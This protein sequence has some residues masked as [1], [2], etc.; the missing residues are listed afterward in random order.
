MKK[1]IQPA[2][3]INDAV[4]TNMIA[5]SLNDSTPS[6]DDEN[7]NFAKEDDIWN[8]DIDWED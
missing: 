8:V 6:V 4:A 7:N 1:Y 5:M 2:T 3:I